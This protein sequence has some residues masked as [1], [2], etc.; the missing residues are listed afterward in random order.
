MRRLLFA[1]AILAILL[2]A[3]QI[4]YVETI[5]ESDDNYPAREY[6][7]KPNYEPFQ[8][9]AMT[10]EQQHYF[11]EYVS[12]LLWNGMLALDWSGEDFRHISTAPYGLG[13]SLNLMM[14]FEDI[15]GIERMGEIWQE[16]DIRIPADI[17]EETLLRFF[18][19]TVEQIREILYAIYDD[20][21]NTYTYAGGRGGGYIFGVVTNVER[22]DG[23]VVLSYSLYVGESKSLQNSGALTLKQT[24]DGFVFWSAEVFNSNAVPPMQRR[25]VALRT[26]TLEQSLNRAILF[27]PDGVSFQFVRQ[28]QITIATNQDREFSG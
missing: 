24:D 11:D 23:Y 28:D 26:P 8:L 14:A 7:Q 21:D 2:T 9:P 22:W 16:H 18:P 3:C 20:V 6:Q 10:A 12:R 4:S 15:V 17:V 5:P 27:Y 19:F 1:F 25:D 13:D